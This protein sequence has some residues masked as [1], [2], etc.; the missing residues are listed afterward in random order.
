M[1]KYNLSRSIP[2]ECSSS[3][4]SRRLRPIDDAHKIWFIWD[5]RS[6]FSTYTNF[7]VGVDYQYAE[8][9]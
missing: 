1:D 6:Y 4:F 9:Q 3:N 2:I 5:L 7:A 8:S